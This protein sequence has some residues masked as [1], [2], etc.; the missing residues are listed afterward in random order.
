MSVR[1]LRGAL[2]LCDRLTLGFRQR[3]L[4]EIIGL[5]GGVAS[6]G[7]FS[8]YILIGR[9]GRKGGGAREEVSRFEPEE[10]KVSSKVCW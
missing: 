3:L 6:L 9:V 4:I 2:F 7:I 5:C 8:V 1:Y 10:R